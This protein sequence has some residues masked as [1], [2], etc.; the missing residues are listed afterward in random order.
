MGALADVLK[1]DAPALTTAEIAALK[2]ELAKPAY[3]GKTSAERVVLLM[4]PVLITNPVA[5]TQVRKT[6]TITELQ[7]WLRPIIFTSSPAL[8]QKWVPKS[9]IMFGL[10]SPDYVVEYASTT[11]A[12]I[13]LEAVADGLI[14]QAQLDEQ[15]PMID[16]PAYQEEIWQTPCEAVLGD[17]AVVRLADV[18]AAEV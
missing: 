7:D 5:V 11:F 13:R 18:L 14:T 15:F 10:Y 12:P 1:Q 9:G 4:A 16:D 3:A 8:Q 17:L 2:A 6:C